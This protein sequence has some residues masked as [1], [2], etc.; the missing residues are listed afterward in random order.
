VRGNALSFAVRAS[1]DEV[2]FDVLVDQLPAIRL[3]AMKGEHLYPL[4]TETSTLEEHEVVLVRRS[5]SWQGTAEI[6]GF[7]SGS[8]T[9]LERPSAA[10]SRRLM[11]IGDSIT[12]G[13]DCGY[14]PND[15]LDGQTTANS[16]RSNARLSYGYLLARE[17]G[18]EVELVSAGGTGMI[19][20]WQGNRNANNMPAFYER[21]LPEDALS[22]WDSASD[23]PD[24]VGICAGT[25]DFSQGVPD[26]NEFVNAYVEF[27]RKVRRDAPQAFI[28]LLESP[29]LEDAVGSVPKRSVLR[30][31]LVDIIARLHD[32]K[33][34]LAPVKHYS[35]LPG[36]GHPMASDHADMVK[37]LEKLFRDALH[38]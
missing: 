27:V 22:H 18:A 1:S 17:L 21:A 30:A 12:C 9:T 36:D 6:V 15:P 7:I 20:D 5:E 28:F 25:N 8:G 10:A 11:F 13:A 23:G 29:I 33:V 4:L 26:Q 14:V 35:G 32:P 37:S 38:W 34:V 3:R 16:H 31:Y 2:Y 19:R 24:A